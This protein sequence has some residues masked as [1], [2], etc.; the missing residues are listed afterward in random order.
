MKFLAQFL[1]EKNT[2]LLI[3]VFQASFLS[4]LGILYDRPNLD[5]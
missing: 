4:Y 3:A 5:E 1:E 2:L